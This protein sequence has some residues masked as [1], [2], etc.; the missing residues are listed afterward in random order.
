[1]DSNTEHRA[2]S[3]GKGLVVVICIIIGVAA[4]LGLGTAL[5]IVPLYAGFLFSLYFG[6]MKG[7]DPHELPAALIGSLGGLLTAALLH[8]LPDQ[9]GTAGLVIALGLI[10]AAIYALVMQWVTILVNNAFMLML[11]IGT[12]PS[13]QAT[14]DF[15]GMAFSVLLAAAMMGLLLLV[16]GIIATRAKKTAG[17]A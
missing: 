12:I 7:S 6:G 9:M 8:L 13:V 1:M 4:Y 2:L 16:G 11:T 3:P 15:I 14:G 17:A 10:L 5:G